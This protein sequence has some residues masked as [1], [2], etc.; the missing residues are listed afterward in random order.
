M[1]IIILA[2]D[3]L[4]FQHPCSSCHSMAPLRQN[5]WSLPSYAPIN[6]CV[7]TASSELFGLTIQPFNMKD[8]NNRFVLGPA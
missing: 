8:L 5:E 2:H 1:I 4:V 7:S 6:G 3:E